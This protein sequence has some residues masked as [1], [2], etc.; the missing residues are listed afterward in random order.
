MKKSYILGGVVIVLAM[1]TAMYSFQSSLT[2]YVSVKEAK[3][4]MQSVQVAGILQNDSARFDAKSQNLIFTLREAGG[5]QMLV[6]YTGTKPINLNETSKIVAIG[7][8]SKENQ[9]FKAKDILVK[10][11][12]KYEGRVKGQ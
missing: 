1:I 5:D 7:K 6:H 8:Y 4:G 12:T 3:A 11:P 2:R 9:Y 10:C